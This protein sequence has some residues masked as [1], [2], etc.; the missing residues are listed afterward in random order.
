MSDEIRQALK[1]ISDSLRAL[2]IYTNG[3][4]FDIYKHNRPREDQKKLYSVKMNIVEA[5]RLFGSDWTFKTTT[6]ILET[7]GRYLPPQMEIYLDIAGKTMD[8]LG[9]PE[10][11]KFIRDHLDSIKENMAIVRSKTTNK[12]PHTMDLSL[13]MSNLPNQYFVQATRQRHT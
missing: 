3:I 8:M 13:C 10:D 6:E 7:L 2:N 9:N 11:L 5:T 1:N 12:E 4:P